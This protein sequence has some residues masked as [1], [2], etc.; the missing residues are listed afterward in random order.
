MTRG[1]LQPVI[2]PPSFREVRTVEQAVVLCTGLCRELLVAKGTLS[3]ESHI[4]NVHV[5]HHRNIV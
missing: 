5:R 3:G 2:F 1:F 4:G